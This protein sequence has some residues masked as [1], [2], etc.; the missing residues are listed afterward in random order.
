MQEIIAQKCIIVRTLADSVS[1]LAP[2]PPQKMQHESAPSP[3]ATRTNT[4]CTALP[5]ADQRRAGR[6]ASPLPS[7]REDA[8]SRP[9]PPSSAGSFFAM[10]ISLVSAPY[11]ELQNWLIS[12]PILKLGTL[13]LFNSRHF[14]SSLID[15]AC[16]V[17]CS[18]SLLFA[19]T[20]CCCCCSV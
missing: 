11:F 20:R 18:F 15:I 6:W 2:P 4:K 16:S 9:A 8:S 5:R 10:L 13:Y 14:L 3:L 12:L 1:R 19:L 7:G 17:L